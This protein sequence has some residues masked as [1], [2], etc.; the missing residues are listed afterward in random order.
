MRILLVE[1]LFTPCQAILWRD[2]FMRERSR[3][4]IF[5]GNRKVEVLQALPWRKFFLT[6]FTLTILI[7]R[8]EVYQSLRA[9]EKIQV[10]SS[11]K[12]LQLEEI[13][14]GK[15]YIPIRF[16]DLKNSLHEWYFALDSIINSLTWKETFLKIFIRCPEPFYIEIHS[17]NKTKPTA[18]R[19]V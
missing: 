7:E 5:G 14:S 16:N 1:T 4:W 11:S 15:W 6:T 8:S 10:L 9:F 12:G 18:T 17:S 13:L 19:K 3:I 2:Y